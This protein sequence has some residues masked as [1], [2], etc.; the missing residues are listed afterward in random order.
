MVPTLNEAEGMRA[1]MPRVDTSV[2]DQVLVV[3]GGSV[4]ETV[5]IAQDF[6]FEV[7]VQKKS[8]IR[9]A[10]I[11]ALPLI[12]GEVVITF[13]PDGNSIP[14]LIPPLIA[15]ISEGFDMVIVSR[16]AAGAHS[17]D[18]DLLTAFGNW[19]FTKTINL[20]HGGNYTDAMVIFRAWRRSIFTELDLHV[21]ESYRQERWFGTVMGCEPLLSVRAARRRLRIT[22]IPGGEPKRIA[23]E[24]KLQ[25]LRWGL[26]YWSQVWWEAV[27]WR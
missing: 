23:G 22:E 20:L 21:D 11:E 19:L 26:A 1:V 15:K 5:H 6:G 4:D 18:D 25:V 13:S 9:H 12:R 14:E 7:Y 8:G 24:R 10:Y 3:D 27:P 16:Y 2:I 17:D